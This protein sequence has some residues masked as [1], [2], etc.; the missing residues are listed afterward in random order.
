[1]AYNIRKNKSVDHEPATGAERQM[2]GLQ[3]LGAWAFGLVVMF[4]VYLLVRRFLF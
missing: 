1:M 3:E 4:L 2:N